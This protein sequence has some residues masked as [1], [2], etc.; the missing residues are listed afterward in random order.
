LIEG[1]RQAWE[2]PM[3]VAFRNAVAHRAWPALCEDCGYRWR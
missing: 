3:L 2:H 1:L